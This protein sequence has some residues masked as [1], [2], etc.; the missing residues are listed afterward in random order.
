VFPWFPVFLSVTAILFAFST[1]ISWS[2]YGERCWITLFGH[3][4]LLVYQLLFLFFAWAGAIFDPQSVLDFGDYMILGMAFPNLAGVILLSGI[5]KQEL[6]L[7]LE[8]LHAGE[9]VKLSPDGTV[10]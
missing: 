1:M 6:D 10:S 2:Y 9:F 8:R 5:V 7:Y 3:R 4:S